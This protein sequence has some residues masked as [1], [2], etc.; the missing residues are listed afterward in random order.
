MVESSAGI[1]AAMRWSFDPFSSITGLAIL[2]S[3]SPL[4]TGP[5]I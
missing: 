2:A 3:E 4:G 5:A 1:A